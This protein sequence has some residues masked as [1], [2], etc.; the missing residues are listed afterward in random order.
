M[1]HIGEELALRGDETVNAFCHAIEI[2]PEV[3]EFVLATSNLVV[4]SRIEVTAGNSSRSLAQFVDWAGD[5]P[6][7]PETEKCPDAQ[8]GRESN[9]SFAPYVLE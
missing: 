6:R 4:D 8:N 3:T 7:Q 2:A 9:D 1:R 5:V